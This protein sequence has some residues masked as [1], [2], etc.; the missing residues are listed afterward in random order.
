VA[1]LAGAVESDSG[2]VLDV[3][4]IFW[5]VLSKAEGKNLPLIVMWDAAGQL[6][7]KL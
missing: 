4:V 3:F 2:F 7:S 1:G 6:P 5:G